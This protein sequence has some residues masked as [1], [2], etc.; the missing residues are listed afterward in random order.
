MSDYDTHIC[1]YTY[2]HVC[3]CICEHLLLCVLMYTS[4]SSLLPP[5]PLS[6]RGKVWGA[7]V[8]Q[9]VECLTRD[10]AQVMIPGLWD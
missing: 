2:I 5:F 3:F 7:W 1:V 10:S 9:S 4:F 6:V 8:A